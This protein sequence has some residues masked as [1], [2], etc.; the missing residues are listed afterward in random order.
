MDIPPPGVEMSQLAN[1]LGWKEKLMDSDYLA[2]F[3]NYRLPC[4]N[5]SYHLVIL[6][7]HLW[8]GKFQVA[9][10]EKPQVTGGNGANPSSRKVSI[11]NGYGRFLAR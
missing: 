2:T 6:C 4:K 5:A 10:I 11:R 8:G 9:L 3:D 1:T 7:G